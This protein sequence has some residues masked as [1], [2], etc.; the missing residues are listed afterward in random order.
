MSTPYVFRGSSRQLWEDYFKR[1]Q[2]LEFGAAHSMREYL[3]HG[4]SLSYWLESIFR[5]S[6][7]T[8]RT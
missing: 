2:Q 4:K 5:P 6:R 3:K 7:I 1:Y 8:R